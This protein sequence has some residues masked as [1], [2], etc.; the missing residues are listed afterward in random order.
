[1]KIHHNLASQV[2]LIPHTFQQATAVTA[3]L[4]SLEVFVSVF[5]P[6]RTGAFE[7]FI[8]LCKCYTKMFDS[9]TFCSI[10][11]CNI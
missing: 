10:Q 7:L 2:Y 6:R 3:C 9:G 4:A 5:I 8:L 11:Q 1:M